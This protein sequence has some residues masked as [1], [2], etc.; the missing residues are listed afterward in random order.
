MKSLIITILLFVA[1]IF[2]YG[3][4]YGKMSPWL[5]K[6]VKAQIAKAVLQKEEAGSKRKGV[7]INKEINNINHNLNSNNN[8]WRILKN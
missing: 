5:R 7:L 4:N 6:E 2:S 1:S 8:L 3:Q